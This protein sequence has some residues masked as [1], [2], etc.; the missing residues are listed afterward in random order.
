L[1]FGLAAFAENNR[2]KLVELL[3]ELEV[4]FLAVLTLLLKLKIL[5]QYKMVPEF[6]NWQ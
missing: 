3:T 6:L 1:L 2:I 5:L 4:I